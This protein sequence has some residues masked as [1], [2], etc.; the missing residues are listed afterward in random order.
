MSLKTRFTA[1]FVVIGLLVVGLAAY[2]VYGLQKSNDGFSAYREMAKDTVLASRVQANMLMVRMKAKDFIKTNSQNDYE[3][4]NKYYEKTMKF[5][6]E[7]L[8]EIQN[9]SRAPKV[10]TIAKE[11]KEYKHSFQEVVSLFKQRNLIVRTNLDVNGKKIEQLLTSV[12]KSAKKDGDKDSALDVAQ[13]IRSLLLARL[14]TTKFLI[15][16]SDDTLKRVNKE[17]NDLSY[18]LEITKKGL[19]NKLRRKQLSQAIALIKKYKNGA[20][21]ISDI[22]KKRNNIIYSKLDA[23]GPNIAT[24]A[25]DVK[26]S[27]KADQDKIGPRVAKDNQKLL[28]ASII[29]AIA[30]VL[31][32]IFLS[33]IVLR[34][35]LIIPLKSLENA[36]KEI[37]QGD[38]DLTR[39]INIQTNDEIGIVARHIDYFIQKVQDAINS[40]K[41]ISSENASVAHELSTTALGVGKNVENSVSIIEGT[42]NKAQNI[43]TQ[44]TQYVQKAQ[45]SKEEIVHANSNLRTAKEEIIT[46]TSKVHESA[47][48]EAELAQNMEALSKDAEEVKTILV[49][50]ADIADQTNLLALNA[51]IEAARAGE[52]G[53]GFAVVADEV[54]KLAERTQKS[55]AEINATIN[56]VVQSIVEAS[57]KMSENSQDIQELSTIAQEV[58]EKISTTVEIVEGAVL[59]SESTVHD[60]EQTNQDIEVVVDEVQKVNEISS[61]NARS[62]EEIA[63]AAEHLNSMT[64][65]LNNKLATFKT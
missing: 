26:L 18:N 28:N 22:I 41:Q 45:H 31:V 37:S 17:F 64:D 5:V 29:I 61:T 1:A 35:G 55:L 56:V 63:A 16:N 43:Q 42:T 34:N 49:V 40:V 59:A 65:N 44:I 48:L 39:R 51:A 19:Q 13:S 53:R 47:E 46:L 25:E 33:I 23:I 8:Q 58:E 11:L 2:L 36:T 24:L 50:I 30:I 14:Y 10:Q 60:F 4:F 6:N 21:K 7:A 3:E 15:S 57:S 27:I 52:H 38:G 32:I 54:R 12:M 62:V 20:T 9:P